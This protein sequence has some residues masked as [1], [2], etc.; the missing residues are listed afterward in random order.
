MIKNLEAFSCANN[1][2]IGGQSINKVAF[3][4]IKLLKLTVTKGTLGSLYVKIFEANRATFFPST[5][6]PCPVLPDWIES[7]FIRKCGCRFGF[8]LIF[9]SLLHS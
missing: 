5:K 3:K 7:V 4:L 9:G 6:L 1:L 2:S 8:Q